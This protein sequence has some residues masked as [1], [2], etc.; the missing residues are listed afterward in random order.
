MKPGCAAFAISRADAPAI[1]IHR[2]ERQGAADV[3]T[4]VLPKFI[5][6]KWWQHILHNQSSLLLKAALLF[7]EGVD[8]DE[9]AI[10]LKALVRFEDDQ[11]WIG[12]E[13]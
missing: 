8:S 5:P 13:F 10:S 6:A 4:V 12:R 9:R 11:L 2:A 1:E 7:K 3:I